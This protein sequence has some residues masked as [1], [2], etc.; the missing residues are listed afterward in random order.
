MK[1]EEHTKRLEEE[2]NDRILRKK[3]A[4][5]LWKRKRNFSQQED[6]LER[7]ILNIKSWYPLSGTA[8]FAVTEAVE[9]MEMED[10]DSMGAH[11]L[12]DILP[13][14]WKTELQVQDEDEDMESMSWQENEEL[15]EKWLV[16]E[17]AG[18]GIQCH[19][20][21]SWME[22]DDISSLQTE[23]G[24]AGKL[25]LQPISAQGGQQREQRVVEP[26]GGCQVRREGQDGVLAINADIASRSIR[27]QE[28]LESRLPG[29]ATY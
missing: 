29:L 20:Q 8:D 13:E 27:M 2:R 11:Y 16:E 21:S 25:Q 6:D 5:E 17:L 28:N 23:N 9:H 15:F 24:L 10:L 3:V 18:M 7:V 1:R 26:P 4:E 22:V 19:W 12:E 14:E